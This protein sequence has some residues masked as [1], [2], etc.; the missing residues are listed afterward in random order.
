MTN[1]FRSSSQIT[2]MVLVVTA[3]FLTI[4]QGQACCTLQAFNGNSS[5]G[6]ISDFDGLDFANPTKRTQMQFQLSGSDDWDK[7]VTNNTISNGPILG[8]AATINHFLR[9]NILLGAAI[10]GN[11]STISEVITNPPFN[12]GVTLHNLQLKANWLSPFRRHIVWVRFTQPLYERYSNEDFPF[13]TST[14]QAVELGYGYVKNYMN[15]RGKPRNLSV[16]VNV[17]KEEET[18]NLYQFDYYATGQMSWRYRIHSDLVP[19]FSLYGKQ[20]SLRPVDNPIYQSIFDPTL[21]AYGLIGG[22][23]E[24]SSESLKAI[25]IRLYGFYPVLR[26][27]NKA[28]PAG[29]EEKPVLGLTITKSLSLRKG[30]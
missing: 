16:M 3:S 10:S 25:T 14:A 17:R 19:F 12:S 20:G 13:E 2:R 11:V 6:A 9:S 4:L 7:W 8:Y 18:E 1:I 27:S 15:S 28:L 30:G 5:F 23:V 22:G 21:F 24:Y 26:W 29:F